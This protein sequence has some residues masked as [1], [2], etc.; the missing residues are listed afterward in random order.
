[1]I[2]PDDDCRCES[3]SDDLFS[4]PS[5]LVS[6]L[7]YDFNP[8]PGDINSC[9]ELKWER[10]VAACIQLNVAARAK[11]YAKPERLM[12]SRRLKWV[13]FLAMLI[14]RTIEINAKR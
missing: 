11:A 3:S 12:A 10:K 13:F 6:S 14:A 8:C 1:M 9:N 7:L 5:I 4:S 2:S